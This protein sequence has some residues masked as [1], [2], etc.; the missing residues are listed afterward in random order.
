VSTH[1]TSLFDGRYG[2]ALS[3][4]LALVAVS[5]AVETSLKLA[6]LR[7]RPYLLPVVA[8]A[9]SAWRGG[10]RPAMLAS[11]AGLIAVNVHLVRTQPW[12]LQQAAVGVFYMAVCALVAY[13]ARAMA[14][15]EREA[16]RQTARLHAMFGQAAVGMA[17]VTLDGQLVEANQRF[18]D[19]LGRSLAE[20]PG[21]SL[22]TVTSPE[23]WPV[24]ATA[25]ED[26]SASR[27]TEFLHDVRCIK[28]DG[29]T[30]WTHVAL[31]PLPSDDGEPDALVAVVEDIH[32]RRSAE[33]ALKLADRQKDDFLALL[34]HELRNPLAPIRTAV[35]LL[36]LRHAPDADSQRLHAVIERQVGHL[37]HLID[38]LLDVSRA[39]RGRIEL[40][41]EP[42]D[43]GEVIGAAV[44]TT[45]PLIDA[46]QQQL[47]VRLP[48]EAVRVDGDR[49]RLTQVVGNLLHN[50][51]KFTDRGG[52]ITLSLRSENGESALE[53]RDT[54][55]GIDAGLLKTIFEPFVQADRSLERSQGGLGIGL[56]LVRR[57]VDLHGGRVVAESAGRGHGAAF[58]VRL[59]A[60]ATFAISSPS[61]PLIAAAPP[62]G[63][64]VLV[65][66]DNVDAADSLA[67]L[68]RLGG[69]AVTVA[70][71]GRTAL[72][73]ASSERPDV[74]LLDIGL[75]GMNGYEVAGALR[76]LLGDGVLIAAVTGYG[77]DAD[78]RRAAEAGFDHHLV[79]PVDAGSLERVL[80][81]ATRK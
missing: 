67:A 37:V 71:D 21:A 76:T 40:R 20:L 69:Q 73:H 45:R 49:V 5:V 57:I 6:W 62:S 53:V 24:V 16:R 28:P 58:T 64:R 33:E 75:P 13:S 48:S 43:L 36:R 42:I 34:S 19:I 50:A 1:R 46:R 74:V 80:A 66:D 63:L 61:A 15:S 47:V 77:Q 59:P 78:A 2:A 9:L 7:D 35:H 32:E 27:Q 3:Y 8:V 68:L 26:L 65:V 4:V 79:K 39:L 25:I 18:A 14:T 30:V 72:E 52:T 22:Q 54:G 44:E 29:N 51:A 38:D 12:G 17:Y 81:T 10:F 31:A 11:L 41:L 55:E 56:T 60:L 23:D 70:Y